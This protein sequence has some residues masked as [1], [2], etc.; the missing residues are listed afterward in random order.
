MCVVIDANVADQVFSET[1][2]FFTPI[3]DWLLSDK[4]GIVYG[5]KQ[6][7]ELLQTEQA[8]RALMQLKRRG[9]AFEVDSQ[10]LEAE[11]HLLR[12]LALHKSNDVHVLAVLRA[13]GARSLVS[14]DRLLIRDIQT[15]GVVPAP[16]P[17]ALCS[18]LKDGSRRTKSH[19]NKVLE[20]VLA[21]TPACP[22]SRS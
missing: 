13:S 16:R 20:R 7:E 12:T 8:R 5:G 9:S 21:H 4:G 11:Q 15:K 14:N 19:S 6:A 18:L 22:R 3:L 1:P 17:K 10:R 2:T